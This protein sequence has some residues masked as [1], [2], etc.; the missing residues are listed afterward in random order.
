MNFLRKLFGKKSSIPKPNSDQAPADTSAP[1]APEQPAA[2]PAQS[3]PPEAT[4]LVTASSVDPSL[5]ETHGSHSSGSV[6]SN[7]NSLS[8][9][10]LPVKVQTTLLTIDGPVWLPGDSPA[11]ELFSAKPDDATAIAFIGGSVALPS[12]GLNVGEQG[13]PCVLSPAVLARAL[14]LFLSDQVELGTEALTRC[15]VSWMVKPKSGFI[16]GGKQ[17]EDAVGAHHARQNPADDPSDYVVLSHLDCT[18]AQW[19]MDLRVVRTIDATCVA[20]LSRDCD[21][22]NPNEALAGLSADLLSTLAVHADLP[23]HPSGFTTPPDASEYI[24]RLD[25]MLI[26]RVSLLPDA[27]LLRDESS[28]VEQLAAYARSEADNLPVRLLFTHALATVSKLRPAHRV[29]WATQADALQQEFPLQEPARSVLARIHHE[30]FA[31]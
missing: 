5:G 11:I 27:P 31:A 10:T 26:L 7:G 19:R 18:S 9:P 20:T 2:S 17:W 3:A 15:L 29:A 13:S 21:P 24:A 14:P 30:S 16:L 8:Q 25:Q 12:D 6:L 4:P 28:M 1:V 23:A 22:S